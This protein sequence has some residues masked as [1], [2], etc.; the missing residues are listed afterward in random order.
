[1]SNRTS[2][3]LSASTDVLLAKSVANVAK[4]L[5]FD[6]FPCHSF[7]AGIYFYKALKISVL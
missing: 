2:P 6:V 7:S 5:G 4:K 1:M 3:D